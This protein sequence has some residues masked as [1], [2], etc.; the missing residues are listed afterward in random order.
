VKKGFVALL[1]ALALIVIVSPGIVG[2]LAEKSMDENL[3][4]AAEETGEFVVTSQGFDRGWFS[5]EGQH[6]VELGHGEIRDMLL[7]LS[8]AD[9]STHVPALIIETH[10]DHGLIPVGSMTHDK[11]SLRPGL[12]SAVSTLGV[13]LDNGEVWPLPGKIHSKVSFTGDLTSNYILEAGTTTIDDGTMSWGEIDIEMTT[14]PSSGD[15]GFEGA[16]ESFELTSARDTITVGNIRFSGDQEPTPYGVRV[17][18][19]DISVD[20]IGSS[21]LRQTMGPFRLKS[22]SSLDDERIDFD[23]DLEVNN[24]PFEDYGNGSLRLELRL[25]DADGGSLANLKRRLERYH[26]DA[27]PSDLEADARR[28]AASG[29]EFHLDKFD[30]SLPQGVIKS[31]VHIEVDEF[32]RDGFAWTSLLLETDARAELSIPAALID[33]VAAGNNELNAAIGLGYL[34][35]DGDAYV[36]KAELKNGML[37]INGAPM[38]LPLLD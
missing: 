14:S 25:L 37:E 38:T 6:R 27:Q 35:R 11:G 4:H 8:G 9:P 26:Y 28:L 3:E 12:G 2:R 10:L 18:P 23:I 29:F 16:V 31:Q 5:S 7:A 33:A 36:L 22:R 13:E 20:T 21:T 17:G 1:L 30:V 32:D 15:I 19:L 34:R 24:A